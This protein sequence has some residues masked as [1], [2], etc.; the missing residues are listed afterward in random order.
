[1]SVDHLK[2]Q[3]Q[4]TIVVRVGQV[5]HQGL[6]ELLMPSAASQGFESAWAEVTSQPAQVLQKAFRRFVSQGNSLHVQHG[7]GKTL[8]HQHV[9]PIMH[10]CERMGR[11][12]PA[13]LGI[14]GPQLLQAVRAQT[15]KHQKTID[16]Q[17]LMPAR[18]ERLRICRHVQRHIGPNH[19]EAAFGWQAFCPGI[20]HYQLRSLPAGRCPPRFSYQFRS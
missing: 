14:D 16:C 5:V 8:G 20:S 1:M 9:A 12:T 11:L 18:N 6:F 10:V 3:F 13:L 7:L 2:A 4:A 15:G 19:L 17:G